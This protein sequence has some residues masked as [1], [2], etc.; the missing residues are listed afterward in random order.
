MEA[1]RSRLTRRGGR[2]LAL[3]LLLAARGAA[4]A[5][6]F[7]LGPGAAL[8]EPDVQRALVGTTYAYRGTDDAS[9]RFTVTVMRASEVRQAL[10]ELAPV[11][12]INVFVEE[13]RNSHERFFVA[14]A[15]RPLLVAGSEFP[16]FRWS[17]KRLGRTRTGVLSCGL[18]GGRYFVIHFV[19]ELTRASRSFPAVRATL[20][21]MRV[22]GAAP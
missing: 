13:V 11:D 18:I 9:L 17:G 14:A 12:C 8:D 1:E 22:D 16:Q 5:P 7:A 21:G 15:Q 19:D 20:S 3:A 10:G 4:A 6:P 2:A